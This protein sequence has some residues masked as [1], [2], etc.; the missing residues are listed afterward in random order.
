MSQLDLYSPY[1]WER[2]TQPSLPGMEVEPPQP[3]QPPTPQDP[4]DAHCAKVFAPAV[5]ATGQLFIKP[6]TRPPTLRDRVREE[7]KASGNA[8][9]DIDETKRALFGQAKLRAFHFVVYN[10]NGG[11]NWLLY[12]GY[13][14]REGREDMQR[15]A[16]V[17]GDG[18]EAVYA[19][20]HAHGRIAYEAQ[21][22]ASAYSGKAAMRRRLEDLK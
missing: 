15:W 7:I 18:F 1:R 21:G 2:H 10:Q 9:V 16:E 6:R 12:C 8:Y 19:L 11:P 17:F 13:P 22:I 14:G 20:P 3:D 4:F 5:A